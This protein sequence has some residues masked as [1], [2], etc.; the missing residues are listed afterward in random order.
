MQPVV[1]LISL[2]LMALLSAVFY[3]AARASQG[4]APGPNAN[5]KR[6]GLIWAMVV[7]GVIVSVGSLRSWPHAL[8]ST[9]DALEVSVSGGQWWWDI[10]T[11]EIPVGKPVNFNVTTED[12]T[13]GM[14]IYD[15]ELTLLTQ[16]QAIPGYTTKVTYTFTEPGSYQLLCMEFCGVAHHDM[17]NEFEVV[18]VEE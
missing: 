2:I 15:S 14:G 13:H 16:V 10:D 5:S 4:E 3:M 8:A 1:L 7:L 11:T 18:A 6:T 9:G 17:V 12:V